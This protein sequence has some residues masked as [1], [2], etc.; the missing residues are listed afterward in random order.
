MTNEENS[1]T[2]ESPKKHK[3]VDQTSKINMWKGI[4]IVSIVAAIVFASPLLRNGTPEQDETLLTQEEIS[5]KVAQLIEKSSDGQ[6]QFSL[7]AVEEEYGLYLVK[8]DLE[9][10]DGPTEQEIR[11]SKDGELLVMQTIPYADI[12]TQ[13]ELAKQQQQQQSNQAQLSDDAIAPLEEDLSNDQ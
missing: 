9:T 12:L 1:S 8:F 2:V 4:S 13:I 3:L 5:E 10:E 6:D 7:S 11:I